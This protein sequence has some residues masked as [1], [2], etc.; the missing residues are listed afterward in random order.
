MH[1]HAL[2]FLSQCL[3]SNKLVYYLY[4]CRRSRYKLRLMLPAYFYKYTDG[5][6][7]KECFGSGHGFRQLE[8][9]S[10]V[11]FTDARICLKAKRTND[12]LRF[13]FA[14]N[15]QRSGRTPWK[16][17]A[18]AVEMQCKHQKRRASSRASVLNHR[19]ELRRNAV[20]R[21]VNSVATQ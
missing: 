17:G 9:F 6:E 13:Q 14:Y 21:S 18:N 3:S 4:I 7:H 12:I 15:R 10:M 11:I 1:I 2:G 5:A 16:R 19:L 20:K 8:V